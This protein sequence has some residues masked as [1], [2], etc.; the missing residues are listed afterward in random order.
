MS[1]NNKGRASRRARA[2]VNI[3]L[4]TATA[5][6]E[7]VLAKVPRDARALVRDEA[8]AS[9]DP[10]VKDL[11]IDL[12]YLNPYQN[13]LEGDRLQALLAGHILAGLARMPVDDSNMRAIDELE[14]TLGGRAHEI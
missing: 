4:S 13:P 11:A 14:G 10:R 7:G 12:L 3:S 8:I 5:P 9:T 2:A 6:P 1:Q